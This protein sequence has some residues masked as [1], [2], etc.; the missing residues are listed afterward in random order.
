M[1]SS[2]RMRCL[3]RPG[4]HPAGGRRAVALDP[5]L[6]GP[7]G[8]RIAGHRGPNS[9]FVSARRIPRRAATAAPY[10]Y[11]RRPRRGSASAS[12]PAAPAAAQRRRDVLDHLV[13]ADVLVVLA[14]LGLR[15][16]REDRLGQPVA[17]AQARRAAA[18]PQTVP[19]SPG[20]P[21]SPSRRGSRGRRPRSGGPSPGRQIMIRPRRS[22]SGPRSGGSWPAAAISA[23]KRRRRGP[24]DPCRA[25]GSGRSPPVSANQNRDRPVRTR[26]LSG[27]AVGRTTSNALIRSEATSTSRPSLQRVQVAD[28]AGA[29]EGLSQHRAPSPGR[30][31]ACAGRR[32]RRLEAVEPG[33]DLGD[34]AQERGVVEAGVELRERQPLGDGRDRPPAGRAAARARRRPAAPRAGRSRRPPRATGRRPRPARPARATRRAGRARAR[35]SRASARSGRRGPRPGRSSGRACSRAGSSRR[36][37]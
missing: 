29:E 3:A 4:R 5:L 6:G 30:C 11:S 28:L 32:A 17:L 13:E 2:I 7:T 34:V 22:S 25:G 19:R 15:R 35:C 24:R 20:T 33:D 26:P 31:A 18:M 12:C 14:L 1:T 23:P 8:R 36:A 9:N 21:S 10:R 27:I 37:G 16:R